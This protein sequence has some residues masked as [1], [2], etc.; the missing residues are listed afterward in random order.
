[1]PHHE[2]VNHS[3]TVGDVFAHR[4]V[5]EMS[6]GNVL[7]DLRPKGAEMFRLKKGEH[8]RI[9][10]EKKPSEIKVHTISREGGER[11]VIDHP[12][13]PHEHELLIPRSLFGLPKRQDLT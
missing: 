7:A 3:G 12:K 4:F 11:V 8:V 9:E 10:G 1:M 5:L 2:Q 13:P 6:N